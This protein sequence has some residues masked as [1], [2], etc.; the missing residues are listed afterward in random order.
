MKWKTTVQS[1]RRPRRISCSI[2]IKSE[3]TDGT[4]SPVMYPE[5]EIWTENGYTPMMYAIKDNKVFMADRFLD[6]GANINAVAKWESIHNV[7]S[8]P[9]RAI[10]FLSLNYFSP[11][12]LMGKV[13]LSRKYR[14]HKIPM[15]SVSGIVKS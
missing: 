8:C 4:Y 14:R 3:R 12:D 9:K 6:M 11:E 1:Y 13:R 2:S 10:K 7:G 15:Q 5:I